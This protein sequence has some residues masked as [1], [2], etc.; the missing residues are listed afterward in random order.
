MSY[1]YQPGNNMQSNMQSNIPG[2][3]T[4]GY[5]PHVMGAPGMVNRVTGVPLGAMGTED[6]GT[7]PGQDHLA[8]YIPSNGGLMRDRVT[9]KPLNWTQP[10]PYQPPAGGINGMSGGSEQSFGPTQGMPMTPWMGAPV[11]PMGNRGMGM[12]W[13]RDI[14]RQ[15]PGAEAQFGPQMNRPINVFQPGG[16]AAGIMDMRGAADPSG[17]GRINSTVYGRR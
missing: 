8:N 10:N 16:P 1:G 15:D 5:N 7:T 14:F 11:G 6:T 4:Q 13:M 17:L 3:G 12:P 2:L 9:G